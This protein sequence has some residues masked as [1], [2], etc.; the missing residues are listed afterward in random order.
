MVGVEHTTERRRA[1]AATAHSLR[2]EALDADCGGREHLIAARR[3]PGS[4]DLGEVVEVDKDDCGG[5]A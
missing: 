4:I 2:R 1:L 3:P 5:N